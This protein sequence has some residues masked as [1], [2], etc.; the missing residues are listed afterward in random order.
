[1]LATNGLPL[2]GLL[3]IVLLLVRHVARKDKLRRR[4]QARQ[5]ERERRHRDRKSDRSERSQMR[6]DA[7]QTTIMDTIVRTESRSRDKRQR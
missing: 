7:D 4:E 6:E 1:M 5:R 2:V 3:M